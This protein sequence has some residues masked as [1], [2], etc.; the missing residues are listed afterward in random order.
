M[1]SSGELAEYFIKHAP[2]FHEDL[3]LKN[4][5]DKHIEILKASYSE[6]DK[7]TAFNKN[8][9]RNW[10]AQSDMDVPAQLSSSAIKDDGLLISILKFVYKKLFR[11]DADKYLKSAFRDDMDILNEVGAQELMLENPVHKTPGA[12]A[13]YHVNDTSINLRWLRYIYALKRILDFKI[14]GDNSIWVDVGSY[15]GGLQGLVHKYA[16]TSRIV[17]VDFHHQL[18]RSFI[19]LSQLYPDALHITPD[20]LKDYDSLEVMP[21]GAFV[22]VPVS[23]YEKIAD[24]KVNLVTNFFSLGEMRREYFDVYHNSRLFNESDMTYI[25]NR[26]VSAPFFDSTYDNDLSIL[27]YY[28]SNR[29]KEYFDIFP[30]HHFLLLKRNVFGRNEFRNMSSPYFELVTSC[31]S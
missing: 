31:V 3:D 12:T 2:K 9:F 26:F 4:I 13:T 11:R 20:E 22:Y 29:K 27:D 17:M 18:C 7:G 16:P 5:D 6:V 28:S 14:L 30:M 23:D 1:K 10:K 21:S 19:Y 25:V 15:Y 24:Q 8:S